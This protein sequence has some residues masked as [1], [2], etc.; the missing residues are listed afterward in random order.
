M[1]INNKNTNNESFDENDLEEVT[2]EQLLNNTQGDNGENKKPEEPPTPEDDGMGVANP[3][4]EGDDEGDDPVNDEGDN[5]EDNEEVNDEEGDEED[6]EVDDDE[7]DD[8]KNKEDPT[9]DS[10]EESSEEESSSDEEDDTYFK[11]IE[12]DNKKEIL[13]DYHPEIKQLKT[14]EMLAMTKIFRDDDGI[15]IDELHKTIPILTRF[16]K[17]RV[18]GLRAKQINKGSEPF[19][20]ISND[21]MDGLT[22]AEM[23]LK[24]KKIPFIIRRP[25]PNGGSEYWNIKDLTLLD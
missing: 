23:E 19:I 6:E 20:K 11:K 15:I 1:D 9:Y 24:E 22:I 2:T 13:I 25:L 14:N 12:N 10:E 8:T 18:I 5:E 4:D 16:E 21:I 7:E 17:A 3:T